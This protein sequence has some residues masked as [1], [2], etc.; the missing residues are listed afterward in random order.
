MSA[1]EQERNKTFSMNKDRSDYQ[2]RSGNAGE[3]ACTNQSVEGHNTGSFEA[4]GTA[5]KGH[6]FLSRPRYTGNDLIPKAKLENRARRRHV[7]RV[8]IMPRISVVKPH[9]QDWRGQIFRSHIVRKPSVRVATATQR[10]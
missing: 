10:R 3:H 7:E 4:K 9:R 2:F 8:D 6:P 1:A 5:P